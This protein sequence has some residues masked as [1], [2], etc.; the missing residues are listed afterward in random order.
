MDSES[1]ETNTL[2]ISTSRFEHLTFG[3]I[4]SKND[5]YFY[6]MHRHKSWSVGKILGTLKIYSSVH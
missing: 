4:N 6:Y 1:D 5:N 2:M 3:F